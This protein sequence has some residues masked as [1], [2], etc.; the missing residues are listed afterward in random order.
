MNIVL[1][2]DNREVN[3]EV[4]NS[5]KLVAF[6]KAS[7]VDQQFGRGSR[8]Q[9]GGYSSRGRQDNNRGFYQSQ[10]HQRGGGQEHQRGRGQD[11]QRGGGQYGQRSET[12]QHGSITSVFVA[13]PK[14]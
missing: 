3:L 9:D 10:D 8:S 6:T 14:Q 2:K 12:M 4:I 11:Y 13:E 7:S 5:S 1:P